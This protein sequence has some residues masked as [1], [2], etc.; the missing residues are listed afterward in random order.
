[1]KQEQVT[2]KT[3]VKARELLRVVC[4]LTGQKQYEVMERLLELEKARLTAFQ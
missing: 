3:T 2:I 4:A 1:M